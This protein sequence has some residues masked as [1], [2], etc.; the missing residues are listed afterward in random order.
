MF[1]I[2]A[3]KNRISKFINGPFRSACIQLSKKTLAA[4]FYGAEK[5]PRS[6]SGITVRPYFHLQRKPGCK[7]KKQP[8]NQIFKKQ[9]KKRPLV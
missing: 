6:K 7:P 3:Q 8:P 4:G 9:P 1:K 5:P 2:I